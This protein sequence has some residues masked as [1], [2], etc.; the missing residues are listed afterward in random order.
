[1]TIEEVQGLEHGGLM[2]EFVATRDIQEDEE[3]FLFYG[4]GWEEAWH[5]HV[6]KW[7]KGEEHSYTFDL[8]DN[9]PIIRTQREQEVDPY[10]MHIFTSCYYSYKNRRRDGREQ[11]VWLL[12]TDIYQSRNLRPCIILQRHGNLEGDF[13]YTVAMRNRFGLEEVDR[14][15]RGEIH[16]VS[17]LPRSAIRFSSKIFT[18]DMHMPNAFRHHIELS[19][20]IF[21]TQWRN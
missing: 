1:M 20:D 11:F 10:P 8:D 14:I 17:N 19:D 6:N 16:I 12:S 21:P 4:S 13:R 5:M 7:K 2:L 3:I 9:S 18:T 15:P